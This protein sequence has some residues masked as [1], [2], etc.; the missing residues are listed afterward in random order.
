MPSGGRTGIRRHPRA[1]QP[2]QRFRG[3]GRRPARRRARHASAAAMLPCSHYRRTRIGF[4]CGATDMTEQVTKKLTV[5]ASVFQ[6]CDDKLPNRHDG[7]VRRATECP[8]NAVNHGSRTLDHTFTMMHHTLTFSSTSRRALRSVGSWRRRSVARLIGSVVGDRRTARL[9]RHG[10]AGAARRNALAF[11]V[12]AIGERGDRRAR[13]V[14]DDRRSGRVPRLTRTIAPRPLALAAQQLGYGE[15]DMI[16]AWS[17][18]PLDH[19]RAV[20]AAMTQVGV[21]YRSNT[22]QEGVGFDCSG[23][24]TYAWGRAGVR[25]VPP[26]RR[27]DQ[28][29]RAARSLD[30]QGRRPRLVPG[31][32]DAVPRCRRRDHPLRADAAAPSRSTRSPV[33]ASNSVRFGDPAA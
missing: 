17:S 26:E 2:P 5:R 8:P 9:R 16:R 11:E 27:A 10:G 19:Q 3:F 12:V 15:V 33:A 13:R 32:R 4:R 24:T 18:T 29:G 22:S 31:P 20:L 1:A 7:G 30:R 25:A 6:L 23:L 14:H 28:R 21:P